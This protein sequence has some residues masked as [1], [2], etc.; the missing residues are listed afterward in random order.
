MCFDVTSKACS[1]TLTAWYLCYI[2]LITHKNDV[3]VSLL[4]TCLLKGNE[5]Q[6]KETW[7]LEAHNY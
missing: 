1:K 3:K 4:L 7:C 6:K 5:N 2:T